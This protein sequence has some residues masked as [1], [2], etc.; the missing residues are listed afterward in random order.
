[1]P[2]GMPADI[3]IIFAV[4]FFL[5]AI[6]LGDAALGDTLGTAFKSLFDLD[7]EKNL[8]AWYS[9]V[10][11]FLIGYLLLQHAKLIIREKRTGGFA[12]ILLGCALIFMSFDEAVGIHERIGLASD[13]LLPG[14]DRIN[15]IVP[16]TGI[17]MLVM[18]IPAFL[19]MFYLLFTLR[20]Q[21]I[22]ADTFR[23]FVVGLAIF[24]VSA[25]GIE[26]LANYSGEGTISIIQIA[27]EELGEMIGAT[28]M[29][30]AAYKLFRG[31]IRASFD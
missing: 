26:L 14:G 15:S 28:I 16:V 3:A 21:T 25:G 13:I 22:R 6:Y 7:R 9:S 24:V 12:V 27:A 11:L 17:W 19:I 31:S 29:L 8:P 10:K 30:W 2:L 23:L 1:M 18:L 4:D 20:K 5:V